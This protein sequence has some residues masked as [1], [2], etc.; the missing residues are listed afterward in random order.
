MEFERFKHRQL[1]HPSLL[2]GCCLR[3]AAQ[4]HGC[5]GELLRCPPEE[6]HGISVGVGIDVSALVGTSVLVARSP[7][8]RYRWCAGPRLLGSRAALAPLA[9]AFT[10]LL[11]H[12]DVLCG[13]SVAR[14]RVH[15]QLLM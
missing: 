10:G 13:L 11:L 3:I 9:I 14:L 4:Q 5:S 15:P 8:S 12:E 1:V 6:R 2:R 7:Q